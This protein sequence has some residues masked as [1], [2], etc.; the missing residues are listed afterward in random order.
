MEA[1]FALSRRQFHLL[2]DSMF[3]EQKRVVVVGG[4]VW[5]EQQFVERDGEGDHEDDHV[6]GV[7]AVAQPQEDDKVAQHHLRARL[8]G[9]DTSQREEC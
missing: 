8:G 1:W 4:E 9:V 3:H 2:T 6:E 5:I 7:E